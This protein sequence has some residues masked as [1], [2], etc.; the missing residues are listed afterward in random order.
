MIISLT[1]QT[2]DEGL[3]QSIGGSTISTIQ[4]ADKKLTFIP[5]VFILLRIWGTLQ[6]IY[7]TGVDHM[8]YF[9]CVPKNYA[10]GFTFFAYVQVNLLYSLFLVF[11]Y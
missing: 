9:G 3:Y 4:R 7:A 5:I 1:G 10:I 6:F 11:R 8:M 2:G